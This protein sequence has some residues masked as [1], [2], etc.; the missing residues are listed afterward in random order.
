MKCDLETRM[1]NIL[2]TTE[3]KQ[4]S[5]KYK[6]ALTRLVNKGLVK[7]TQNGYMLIPTIV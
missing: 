5:G 4:S 6:A 1:L 3:I 2:K 7:K